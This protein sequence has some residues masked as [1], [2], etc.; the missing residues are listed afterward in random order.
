MNQAQN[1][2]C[3]LRLR[4]RSGDSL[5]KNN[6]EYALDVS[7]RQYFRTSRKMLGTCAYQHMRGAPL[8][9]KPTTAICRS[10]AIL[11]FPEYGP[12][13]AHNRQLH[14]PTGLPG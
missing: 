4:K 2:R 3:F 5:F 1:L 7:V 12:A 8:E 11:L 14:K 6:A 13:M 9:L 10:L